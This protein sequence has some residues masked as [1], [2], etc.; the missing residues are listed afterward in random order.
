MKKLIVIALS[1]MMLFAFTACDPSNDVKED[2][3]PEG[4]KG[5]ELKD[6]FTSYA[7]NVTVD[8]DWVILGMTKTNAGEPEAL[9]S[10]DGPAIKFN[11]SGVVEFGN[12]NAA[13]VSYTL[14]L[15]SLKDNEYTAWS[16]NYGDAE[17]NWKA[18]TYLFIQKT[19]AHEYTVALGDEG[20]AHTVI[21]FIEDEEDMHAENLRLISQ[22][23]A[24]RK[25][26]LTEEDDIVDITLTATKSD[27]AVELS[28][29]VEGKT[30]TMNT[31]N[32]ESA[33]VADIA[34]IRTLWNVI[35]NSDEVK[36]TAYNVQ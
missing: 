3:I 33:T 8:G 24:E 36:M 14:N 17:G 22:V 6:L 4:T 9:S 27:D 30:I 26:T 18:D 10:V 1:V 32:P 34:G 19:A 23:P 16:L 13:T 12:N 11:E 2:P 25:T 31:F 29:T 7:D 35:S 5:A 28:A 21:N 15:S 20:A